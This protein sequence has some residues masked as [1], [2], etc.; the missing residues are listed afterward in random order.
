MPTKNQYVTLD[1]NRNLFSFVC[2]IFEVT[3]K[4][5]MCFKLR[6]LFWAGNKPEVRKG[7]Q[8]CMRAGKCPAAAIVSQRRPDG[9]SW[10]DDY[11]SDTPVVGKIR[12][13]VLERIQRPI[14]VEAHY[15]EFPV[16][17]AERLKIES[18]SD[19]IGK[20]IGAAPLP[21]TDG[22]SYSRNFAETAAPKKPRKSAPKAD[23]TNKINEAAASGDLA[24]AINAA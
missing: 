19:R 20:M 15:R 5:S 4:I 13:D 6:E 17:D 16:S 23:N 11:A 3:T 14:V 21:T 24:A 8:A 18:S 10:Q 2:P 7:C 12:K 9:R 22:P 1:D